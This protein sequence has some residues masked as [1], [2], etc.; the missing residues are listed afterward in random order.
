[1]SDLKISD[2]VCEGNIPGLERTRFF[3]RQLVTPD[4]LTQDQIYFRD[5]HRRHNRMLHGWG[6]VCGARVKAGKEKCQLVVENGYILGPYGDEI[7]IPEDISI[8]VCKQDLDGNVYS[9]CG[10]PSDP[11]CRDVRADRRPNQVYYLAV[12]YDECRSRPVS[13]HAGECGC[14]EPGCEYSRIRDSFA[15]KVLSELPDSYR[16]MR[17]PTLAQALRCTDGR[18]CPPCPQDPWVILADL[19]M[20]ADG[21]LEKID[22]YAHRRYVISF[23]EYYFMCRRDYK[24]IDRE[25]IPGAYRA[26]LVDVRA[27]AENLTAARAASVRLASGEWASLPAHFTVQP[28]ETVRSFLAREGDRPYYDTSADE[29]YTLR[30]LYSLAGVRPDA[31]LHSEQEALTP[32]EGLKLRV[33]DMR[34]VSQGL[35][36]LLDEDG[37]TSLEKNHLGAPEASAELSAKYLRGLS[38]ASRLGKKV[39]GLSIAEIAAQPVDE[40]I[41]KALAGEPERN[42]TAL[43]NQAREVWN[44][45]ARVMR[46]GE[47]WKMG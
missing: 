20:G 18:G 42:K 38:P 36:D 24:G 23:A 29:T 12:R 1:M 44:S 8:D 15:V 13:V 2:R 37:L 32:L 28:G 22:C 17:P 11:W 34:V 5:K 14:S 47:T 25:M 7:I 27:Q 16:D 9:A 6:V 39:G 30:E 19:T 41:K 31:V 10:E 33:V 4:D 43:E 26:V 21:S 40:F 35:A 3:P 45:A 46:L